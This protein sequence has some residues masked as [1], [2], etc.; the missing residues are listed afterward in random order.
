MHTKFLN[1]VALNV[2]SLAFSLRGRNSADC[3]IRRISTQ[4]ILYD[5]DDSDYWELHLHQFKE[6][7]LEARV[8]LV[9]LAVQLA[10]QAL[11][12]QEKDY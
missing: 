3:P 8:A 1:F 10:K 11:L 7:S 6:L 9:E 12:S 4:I 2:F 5:C